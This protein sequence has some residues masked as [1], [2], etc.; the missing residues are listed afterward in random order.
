MANPGRGA[1]RGCGRP[2]NNSR[3]GPPQ[4]TT[5]FGGCGKKNRPLQEE[6]SPRRLTMV[7]TDQRRTRS[8]V[9]LDWRANTTPEMTTGNQV[10]TNTFD[11]L[12]QTRTM[13][14]Q[15][16]SPPTESTQTAANEESEPLSETPTT[17]EEAKGLTATENSITSMEIDIEIQN[18]TETAKATRATTE[19]HS[20]DEGQSQP[21]IQHLDT[22]TLAFNEPSTIPMTAQNTE[23]DP[24]QAE[25]EEEDSQPIEEDDS[26]ESADPDYTS[27]DEEEDEDSFWDEKDY[28][29]EEHEIQ[30]PPM[31]ISTRPKLT[32]SVLQ[33]RAEF[34]STGAF[35]PI[36]QTRELLRALMK[37]PTILGCATPDNFLITPRNFPSTEMKF[38]SLAR[39]DF[40]QLSRQKH[41][42]SVVIDLAAKEPTSI[43]E[44]KTKEVIHY[45]QGQQISLDSHRYDD[46]ATV[47]IGIFIGLH[48]KI[49]NR[50]NLQEFIADYHETA[51]DEE[52]PEFEVYEKNVYC[53]YGHERAFARVLA[54]KC[55]RSDAAAMQ[56]FLCAMAKSHAF[57]NAEFLPQGIQQ[58]LLLRKLAQ[59][60]KYVSETT[61]FPI[62][63][64][65]QTILATEVTAG[66][67]KMPLREYIVKSAKAEKLE[68]T[69]F[70]DR[71]L[72]VVPKADQNKAISFVDNDLVKIF[73]DHDLPR[74]PM[75]DIPHRPGSRL[76]KSR[77]FNEYTDSISTKIDNNETLGRQY[78]KP[79]KRP[80]QTRLAVSYATAAA[81]TPRKSPAPIQHASITKNVVPAKEVQNMKQ[82]VRAQIANNSKNLQA[83]LSSQVMALQAQ[84][85]ALQGLVASLQQQIQALT[86]PS[87]PT[88]TTP[89]Q[90][91]Q[92]EVPTEMETSTDKTSPRERAH[93]R[94]RPHNQLHLDTTA[95]GDKFQDSP[96]DP[97]T[98]AN[99][100][101]PTPPTDPNHG[102]D[103]G[104]EDSTLL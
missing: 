30:L 59:Q 3:N 4:H 35:A 62:I 66:S 75:H 81:Q 7:Q 83:D 85:S 46:I 52:A 21:T 78:S 90:T 15:T 40:C 27:H 60:N 53:R 65:N 89:G 32:F 23:K 48:E 9:D 37:H 16:K 33:I 98:N 39:T 24:T 63:G 29:Q 22:A 58:T 104:E 18:T 26:Q 94:P 38:N 43:T 80:Q 71:W 64:F 61:A 103:P 74:H 92:T 96:E 1:G 11:T 102:L 88:T 67:T 6:K 12:D 36:V 77:I 8:D 72:L 99:L 68:P 91:A 28:E 45:L 5:L 41:K 49:T 51:N 86:L 55:G 54:L 25:E 14:T 56:D 76:T 50:Q 69:R 73:R 44:L 13:T 95:P 70:L 97:L 19:T 47:E 31:P 2:P 42:M 20:N 100:T 34:T 93:K 57:G 17:T 10:T 82:S 87:H 79:P 101:Q 84:I